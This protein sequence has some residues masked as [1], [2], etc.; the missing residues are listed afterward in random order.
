MH[1]SEL[2]FAPDWRCFR[3][4]VRGKNEFADMNGPMQTR[5]SNSLICL[6]KNAIFEYRTDIL[7]ET[8]TNH[9]ADVKLITTASVKSQEN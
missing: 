4:C 8:K 5:T 3:N 7:V 6:R 2:D 9:R 1:P